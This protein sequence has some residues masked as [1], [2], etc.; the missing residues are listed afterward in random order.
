[1]AYE[2]LHTISGAVADNLPA[3]RGPDEASERPCKGGIAHRSLIAVQSAAGEARS[4]SL[5][6]YRLIDTPIELSSYRL[7]D[8]PI[9]LI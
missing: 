9:E 3:Q 4:A 2:K 6:S 1:M 5:G 7:I 8:T